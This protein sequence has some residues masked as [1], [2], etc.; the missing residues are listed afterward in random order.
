[1]SWPLAPLPSSDTAWPVDSQRTHGVG[2]GI[3]PAS[4]HTTARAVPHRAVHD[5]LWKRR[6]VF[7]DDTSPMCSGNDFGNAAFMWPAQAFHQVRCP[8]G[9]AHPP[10]RLC[11]SDIRRCVPY[12]Y[13][14]L[15]IFA[16]SPRNVAT[17]PLPVRQASALRSASFRFAVPH[18]TLAVQ[19]LSHSLQVVDFKGLF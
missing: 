6:Y 14:S 19:L 4:F 16:A 15:P 11:V 13:R 7:T 10:S 17:Y 9:I 3:T 2:G 8:R 18:D 5:R 12:K 1:M